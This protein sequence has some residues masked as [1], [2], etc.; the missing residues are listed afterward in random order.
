MREEDKG[1]KEERNKEKEKRRK[2]VGRGG[3]VWCGVSHAGE[4]RAST[5]ELAWTTT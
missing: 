2:N 4:E 1:G 3:R 5:V